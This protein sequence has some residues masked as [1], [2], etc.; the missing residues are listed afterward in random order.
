[1]GCSRVLA[2]RSGSNVSDQFAWFDRAGKLLE[3]VGPPGSYR[4]PDLSPYLDR[5]PC[6]TH[7]VEVHQQSAHDG[8]D[9]ANS[10]AQLRAG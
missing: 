5:R 9:L 2:F 1:M 6:A 10:R 7:I 3:T 8:G 4:A